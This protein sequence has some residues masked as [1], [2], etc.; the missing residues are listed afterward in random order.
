MFKKLILSTILLVSCLVGGEAQTT[1]YTWMYRSSPDCQ[2]EIDG[3]FSSMCWDTVKHKLFKCMPGNDNICNTPSEWNEVVAKDPNL[4]AQSPL[5]YANNGVM[6][7]Q[8]AT[9]TQNGY[10]S[11]TDHASVTNHIANTSNPHSTTKSQVGLSNV[12]NTSD[13]NKPVSTLTQVALNG[14]QNTLT[15]GNI[16]AGTGVSISGGTNAII[17][18]GVTVTNIAPDQ[19]V[20]LT[21]G[22]GIGVSGTYPSFTISNT[23]TFSGVV[24]DSPLSGLGTPASHLTV[25]LSS[26]ENSLGVPSSDD[27][28]LSSKHDGTR[29][30]IAPPATMIYPSA[31]LAK[32]NGI[33]WDASITDNS[34][35]WNTAYSWGNWSSNFGTTPGTIAQG[36]DSRINNGQTAYSWG[37]HAS[38]G[39]ELQSNKSNDTSLSS[40]SSIYYTTQ[41]ATKTYVDNK[42]ANLLSYRG[43]YNASVNTYPTTGGSGTAG[44]ILKGNTWVIS[45]NGTLG[46]SKVYVGDYIVANV[47]SPSQTVANWDHL[48]AGIDFVPEDQANKVTSIS[49]SSTDVQ[50]PS[51]KLLYDQLAG[52]QGTLSQATGSVDGYLYHDD[53]TTFN[54]KQSNLSLVAGTYADGKACTY[55]ASGTILNC[56]TTLP[57]VGTWGAL[58]YPTWASGTPF[59][60][61]TAAGTFALD[62]NTYLTSLSGAVLTDQTSGQTIGAT[63]S[64]LSKL[65]ATDLTVTNAIAGSITGNA[66][67]VTNGVYSS[68]L[69]AN[70]IPKAGSSTTIVDGS[71]YD[72][73][74]NIGIGT[75]SPTAPLTVNS[76]A[77]YTQGSGGI[78]TTYTS[79]GNTYVVHKFTSTGAGTFVAPS[80][81]GSN[82]SVLVVAGG[83]GASEAG[84]GSGGLVYQANRPYTNGASYAL[85]VGAG[86]IIVG[87]DGQDGGN[88]TFDTITAVGGAGSPFRAN[89]DRTGGSGAGGNSVGTT[90]GAST[91][92][93]SGGGTGYGN[94]GGNFSGRSGGGGGA[95]A[96]GGS[97]N[98]GT[99]AGSGGNGL[100]YSITGVSTYYA[101]GG[102]ASNTGSGT[103]GAGGLGGGG[104]GSVNSGANGAANTGGG[105]GGGYNISSGTGGSG[106][107]IVSYIQPSSALVAQLN[108]TIN[109]SGD[110]VGS[111]N[112]SSTTLGVSGTASVSGGFTGN[113]G[114]GGVATALFNIMTNTTATGNILTQQASADA[115]SFD[116]TFNKT[117]GT[118]ASPTV[119]TTAD[120]LGTIKFQGYS[121]AGGYVTGVEIKAISEGT[122]ATTRVPA[123]LSFWT[124]TDASPTVSTQRLKINSV[125]LWTLFDGTTI[126]LGTTTGTKIGTSTSEKLGFYNVAPVI[127]AVATTDLGT[128]LSNVGLR[129]AGTAYPIT[130]S[131]AVNLSGTLSLPALGSA[132]RVVCWKSTTSIG[133][134]SSIVG[135]D[136]S[137]TCN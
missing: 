55:T 89:T 53:W 6:S 93:N 46:G 76:Y 54:G 3:K 16:T 97:G 107:V 4:S 24:V 26:K 122:I 121:G 115:D 40:D 128:V 1:N 15:L 92:G 68:G 30:W 19:V 17:G 39:Y 119:I 116:L 9:D 62:T 118:I 27:Y 133:Y 35:N 112:I 36:N 32:S 137:C 98:G 14:K 22:T 78:I 69:T 88:S 44:A 31:G 86:G 74:G 65:W 111:G 58:D 96:V 51:A 34:S 28:L 75:T 21:P 10:Q 60:K 101:G 126:N 91:Q 100:A 23:Q 103:N 37:N 47:D 66:A 7:I 56:N 43:S 41:H 20:S 72:Y 25:D 38:A 33:N 104:D 82:L 125:G 83:G 49:I 134:C 2:S 90:G 94:N 70:K 5:N 50:Y 108:G 99:V 129:A 106:V 8:V 45:V 127:Q 124:G 63:G 135:A 48:N 95:G 120:E 109:V 123:S 79:G 64:R 42:I 102:G 136:G 61:M 13:I 80:N 57:S 77:T 73:N 29:A 132:N 52:K 113:V 87:N 85:S 114:V 59:V 11:Y 117:R 67:T 18:T 12:D 84:G 71:I 81:A 131:G 110:I 105:G 130:T